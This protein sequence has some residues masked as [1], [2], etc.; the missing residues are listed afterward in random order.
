M[1]EDSI[2]IAVQTA[3]S[4]SAGVAYQEWPQRSNKPREQT[5]ELFLTVSSGK[6]YYT[7]ALT[8]LPIIGMN[9]ASPLLVLAEDRQQ[10]HS[11]DSSLSDCPDSDD[12]ES[13]AR[14]VTQQGG[15]GKYEAPGIAVAARF[16]RGLR[17]AYGPDLWFQVLPIEDEEVEKMYSSKK[18]R[19]C[20]QVMPGK[21]FFG[22][23]T[24][25][26]L[27]PVKV[28][29]TL[30]KLAV[31]K[32]SP[33]RIGWRLILFNDGDYSDIK[34]PRSLSGDVRLDSTFSL[35]W[36]EEFDTKQTD[37]WTD[38]VSTCIRVALIDE[39]YSEATDFKTR[40]R[41]DNLLDTIRTNLARQK[42]PLPSA[43]VSDSV[44]AKTARPLSD[45]HNE[46]GNQSPV[47]LTEA[48]DTMV[49]RQTTPKD[50]AGSEN[51]LGKRETH[52]APT[53]GTSSPL[54]KRLRVEH[55]G[56][57]SATSQHSGQGVAAATRIASSSSN[58]VEQFS[59]T[60]ALA[61]TPPPALGGKALPTTSQ[62]HDPTTV[63]TDQTKEAGLKAKI[64]TLERTNANLNAKANRQE[65]QL[66]TLNQQQEKPNDRI[67]EL[68]D[69]VLELQ[70]ANASSAI[71]IS[72]QNEQIRARITLEK[73]LN[74]KIRTLQQTIKGLNVHV[75]TQ[76]QQ[77]ASQVE[78]EAELK[79][80]ID[81]LQHTNACLKERNT[82]LAAENDALLLQTSTQTF[83][84]APTRSSAPDTDPDVSERLTQANGDLKRRNKHLHTELSA[85]SKDNTTLRHTNDMLV[86]V[87][88]A[89]IKHCQ[90][91]MLERLEMK[92]TLQGNQGE[93]A[94]RLAEYEY[95]EMFG[96]TVKK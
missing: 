73:D 35:L 92:K 79:E 24:H 66:R 5:V 14:S 53:S 76:D 67:R 94:K 77:L 37:Q 59:Q 65:D 27:G 40:V 20:L 56:T 29:G 12:E 84:Q 71:R 6:L 64:R 45:G 96:L 13:S 63:G 42:N 30:R 21:V 23:T 75:H 93:E 26:K 48:S 58:E 3:G 11:S 8:S 88:N 52:L 22:D 60:P 57:P 2:T 10:Q 62:G 34:L 69:T 15:L 54:A 78:H 31:L 55:P 39:G 16:S 19:S 91:V 38:R 4:G 44:I 68:N 7:S 50:V 72:D 87:K 32:Q 47:G 17:D 18:N 83:T 85:A 51:T 33:H 1:S 89:H 80:Q 28:W 82:D 43:T 49:S 25:E 74:D 86:D 81:T 46:L 36:M 95:V 41:K 90:P 9:A 70:N 61:E